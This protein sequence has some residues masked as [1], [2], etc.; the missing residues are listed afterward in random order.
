M[1]IEISNAEDVNVGQV[2]VVRKRASLLRSYNN[3]HYD[4]D[5][6]GN[7]LH[8]SDDTRRLNVNKVNINREIDVFYLTKDIEE[9]LTAN[10]SYRISS[11]RQAEDVINTVTGGKFQKIIDWNAENGPQDPIQMDSS[12]SGNHYRH[13]FT[14]WHEPVVENLTAEQIKAAVDKHGSAYCQ[15][16]FNVSEMEDGK[17]TACY[18]WIDVAG[19]KIP[20]YCWEYKCIPGLDKRRTAAK[21]RAAKQKQKKLPS[22]GELKSLMNEMRFIMQGDLGITIDVTS[23]GIWKITDTARCKSA[24]IS[25][26]DIQQAL[27]N[28]WVNI[29]RG[30]ARHPFIMKREIMMAS[31]EDFWVKLA[32]YLDELELKKVTD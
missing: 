5:P 13:R 26:I 32:L 14:L 10:E 1:Q 20:I 29:P 15:G 25:L 31:G 24:I 11:G 7:E 19:I 12:S 2:Y 27:G 21:A 16:H 6:D 18:L 28:P 23:G 3:E 17:S 22:Q 30:P 4:R 8:W 9:V